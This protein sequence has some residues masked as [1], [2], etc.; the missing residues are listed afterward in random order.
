MLSVTLT[1]GDKDKYISYVAT[2][3]AWCKVLRQKVK[4]HQIIIQPVLKN[5]VI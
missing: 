2:Q 4:G 5:I 3:Q 1:K